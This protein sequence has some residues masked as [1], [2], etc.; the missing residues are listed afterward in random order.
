V[1]ADKKGT[2]RLILTQALLAKYVNGMVI[3]TQVNER[4]TPQR[5]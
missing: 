2:R 1:A 3:K 4:Q 5:F